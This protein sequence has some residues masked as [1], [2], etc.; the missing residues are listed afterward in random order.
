[1]RSLA[2]TFI[3]SAALVGCASG[4]KADGLAGGFTELQLSPNVWQVTFRGNGYTATERAE[5]F[6]LLRAADLTLLNGFSHFALV[7][8]RTSQRV[9]SFTTPAT[10]TTNVSGYR[11]GNSFT[12]NATSTTYGGGTQFV[13]MP[14]AKNTVMMFKGA[15]EGVAAAYDAAFLCNSIGRKYEVSCEALAPKKK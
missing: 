14:S 8:S 11:Y 12:G 7:D 1:M 2:F 9:E 10:T 6:A 3:L 13:T 4:Y 15:P 5:N